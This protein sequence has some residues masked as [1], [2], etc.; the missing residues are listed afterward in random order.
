MLLPQGALV[1]Q[2]QQDQLILGVAQTLAVLTTGM[3]AVMLKQGNPQAWSPAAQE[4]AFMGPQSPRSLE[5]M[6]AIR[7]NVSDVANNHVATSGEPGLASLTGEK[8]FMVAKKGMAT[9]FTAV[10][11]A[12]VGSLEGE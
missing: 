4:N 9:A 7:A 12:L 2:D 8:V 3:A 1:T 5:N 10:M 11:L 6:C